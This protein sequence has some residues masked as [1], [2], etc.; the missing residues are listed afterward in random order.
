MKIKFWGVRGSIPTP[1]PKTV[2]YGGNTSCIEVR[3]DTGDLIILDAGSGIV[4]LAYSLF[5]ELPITCNLFLTHTHWDHIQGLPFFIPTFIPGNTL[6]IHGPYDPVAERDIRATLSRQM[7]Y[8]FFPVRM[9]EL[10]ANIDFVTLKERD[11]VQV[12]GA[13]IANI[14]MNH[15]VLNFGYRITCNGKSLFFTGDHEEFYNIYDPEDAEFV[16]FAL[17]I[18]Q[19]KAEIID[20]IRGC[21]LLIVDSAYTREDYPAKKGWGHGTFD[22]SISMARQAGI[23]TLCF[24]HHEP[25][26][27]DDG[28]EKVFQEAMDRHPR[29]ASDPDY[30]LAKEGQ[31]IEL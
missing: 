4:P 26:R 28:L 5:P 21:D 30:I 3:T 24:V 19:R 31:V 18:E 27:S 25:S 14:L 11:T 7:E 17:Y 2:R 6:H 22:S 16:E 13:T 10:K 20:F 23:K 9:A 1:G 8:S 29:M 12:G 15:P